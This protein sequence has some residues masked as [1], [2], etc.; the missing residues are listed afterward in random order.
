MR[1]VAIP[2]VVPTKS[3]AQAAGRAAKRGFNRARLA[4]GRFIM[5]KEDKPKSK[6]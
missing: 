1:K 5:P 3:D 6:K 2:V 4:I